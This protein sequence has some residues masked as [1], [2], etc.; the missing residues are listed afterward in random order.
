MIGPDGRNMLY[1]LRV[2]LKDIRPPVWRMLLVPQQATLHDLHRVLQAA[3]G[4]SDSH[5]YL[6]HIGRLLYGEPSLEWGRDIRNSKRTRLE[7]IAH[8][9]SRSFLYEY[10]MGDSWMHE[11]T[12]QRTVESKGKGSPQCTDGARA[13][14]PEDCGGPPGYEDFLEAISDPRHEQHEFMMDWA[15][16]EFDPEYFDIAAVNSA[17]RLLVKRSQRSNMPS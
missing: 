3:M 6:F 5:L 7:E 9:G 13:C 10:D 14:P 2:Q 16:G 11:I 4:W 8:E 1:E 17:L 12:L 15:D